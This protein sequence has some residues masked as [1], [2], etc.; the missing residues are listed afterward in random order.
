MI[1]GNGQVRITDFGLAAIAGEVDQVRVGTPAYMAPEQLSGKGVSVQSDL[2]ALGLVLY[3]VFTGK[4]AYTA[5]NVAELVRQHQDERDHAAVG[6]RPRPRPVDRA[7]DPALPRDRSRRAPAVGAGGGRGAA[8]RRPA[9]GRAGGRRDAVAGDG[10]GRGR[11]PGR[12]VALGRP[13]DALG[14]LGVA[15]S[16]RSAR[17]APS[18]RQP[19]ALRQASRRPCRSRPAGAGGGRIHRPADRHALG[20]Q[21]RRRLPAV[22][23]RASRF[24]AH[25]ESV[26][27]IARSG[28]SFYY[29]TSPRRL[30]PLNLVGA[31][32]AVRPAARSSRA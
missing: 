16:R 18:A 24:R 25:G 31:D 3:E 19:D 23:A 21:R 15:G 8:R 5:A 6:D 26:R 13:C 29:R 30:V 20:L 27:R 22:R 11:T 7:R 1:D 2:Y 12:V 10:R 17:G 28:C 4:R 32:P 14:V 9:R